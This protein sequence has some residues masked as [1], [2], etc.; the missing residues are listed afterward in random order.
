MIKITVDNALRSSLAN[1]SDRIEFC[2]ES[3]K[4]VG[5]F[6]PAAEEEQLLYAW[7]RDQISEAEVVAARS[8][9]GGF[10]LEQILAD[11]HAA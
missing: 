1:F 9:A 4:T 10:S 11:L 5:F 7:A 6:V 3:G 2:D 8:Q